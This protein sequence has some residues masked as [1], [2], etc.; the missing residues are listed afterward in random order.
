MTNE[1]LLSLVLRLDKP[2][3]SYT[4]EVFYELAKIY[5][6]PRDHLKNSETQL[7]AEKRG[8]AHSVD[9]DNHPLMAQ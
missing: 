6:S 1:A 7:C 5:F 4:T 3:G 8:S 2:L 9:P